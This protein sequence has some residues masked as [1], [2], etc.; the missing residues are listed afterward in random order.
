MMANSRSIRRNC[1]R[2]RLRAHAYI[3]GH[4]PGCVTTILAAFS[5]EFFAMF[6]RSGQ[7]GTFLVYVDRFIACE[8]NGTQVL[9]GNFCGPEA[10]V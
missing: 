7:K 5:R 2:L 9:P 4:S 10:T 3:E 1:L 6:A 8:G